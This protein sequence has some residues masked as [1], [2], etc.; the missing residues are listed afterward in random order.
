MSQSQNPTESASHSN[1]LSRRQFVTRTG[2]AAL[3]FTIATPQMARTYGANS[4]VNL[5][6]LLSTT[7]NGWILCAAFS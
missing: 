4:K 7:F 3:S 6:R 2:A 1:R 5:E